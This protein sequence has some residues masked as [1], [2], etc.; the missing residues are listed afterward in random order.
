MGGGGLRVGEERVAGAADGH[1][2]VGENLGASRELLLGGG[3][4]EPALGAEMAEEKAIGRD[5]GFW[6][7]RSRE[8]E[9]ASRDL[10]LML[11]VV[12]IQDKQTLPPVWDVFS[13]LKA[14]RRGFAVSQGKIL[15][16]VR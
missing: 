1:E 9:K 8:V 14:L 10:G 16:T 13:V 4:V 7:H 6:V 12:G 11:A 3:V 15:V 2:G 5:A